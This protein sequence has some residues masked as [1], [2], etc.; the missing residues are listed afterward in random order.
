MTRDAIVDTALRATAA[1]GCQG[2]A[3]RQVARELDVSLATVQ[4]H[5]ATKDDLWRACIDTVMSQPIDIDGADGLEAELHG[6]LRA[7]I[8]RA[9]LSPAATAAMWNDTGPGCDERIAYLVDKVR[10]RYDAYRD[11]LEAAMAAGDIRTVEPGVVLAMVG[12]GITSMASAPAALRL[13][14]GIDLDDQGQRDALA[15]SL[16]DVL[17][18]GIL[19]RHATA[20]AGDASRPAPRG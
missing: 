8:D 11:A 12:L 18:H 1:N 16:A 17:L 20:P 5:F 7:M 3:L 14:F 13:L 4:R 10:P 6:Y 15:S 9:T 19:P 2:L